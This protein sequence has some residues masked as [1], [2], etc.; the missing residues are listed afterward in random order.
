[1]SFESLSVSSAIA[2]GANRVSTGAPQGHQSG[3]DGSAVLVPVAAILRLEAGRRQILP[4][5]G[6]LDYGF[7]DISDIG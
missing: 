3:F 6:Q 5:P 7:W 2:S 4:W 1:M